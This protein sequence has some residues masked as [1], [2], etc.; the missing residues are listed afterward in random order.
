MFRLVLATLRVRK[1]SAIAGFLAL[2]CAALIVGACGVLLETGIRGAIPAERYSGTPVVVA[3]DQ[4]IRWTETKVKDKGDGEVKTKSKEKAK[5]LSERAWLPTSVGDKL[6]AVPGAQVIEDLIFPADVLADGG[7]LPGVDGNPTWG[8]GWSSAALT[9]YVLASGAEPRGDGDVVID[10]ELADRAGL[11]VGDETVVQSTSTPKTYRVTGIARPEATVD[12]QS[13]LFFTA[14]EARRLAGHDGTVSAYGVFGA[15]RDQVEA[16]VAGTEAVVSSGD[17]RGAVE[18]VDAAS[19][20]VKLTSMGGALA[21]TSLIV[22]ML[23]VVGTFALAVQ[24]RYREL[25]MLRAIGATPRQ[26]RKMISRE[27]L[28][29]GVLAAIPGALL[30]IPLASVIRAKFVSLGTI[31]DSLQLARSPFPIIAAMAATVGAAFIAARVTA[32]RTARIRP[33]E[34]LAEAAI[35]R[36][37]LGL[38]R[39]LAGLIFTVLAAC[40]T[41]LLTVLH[42]EPAAMPV[43][44]LSVLM[45]M[46]ALSLLGPYLTRG[47]I[48][49]LGVPL[50][51]FPVGGFLAALNSK[52]NSRRVASVIT[53]LALLIGMTSTILFVP[54]TLSDAAA[55]EMKAG[56]KADYVVASLG[57]G[58]PAPAAEALR[59]TPGVTSVTEVLNTTIWAGQDKRSAQG[60]SSAGVATVVDP[61]VTTGSLEK[62]A[63]GSIAMSDLAVQ[64]RKIGDTVPV[65]MGDGV[66]TKFQLVAVY[67]RALGFGDVLLAHE[68]VV[69]HVDAPLAR[70]VLIKGDVSPDQLRDRVKDFPG[71]MVTDRSGFQEAQ[72]ERQQTNAEVN[73]VFMGLIIAFT[74]IAV[75]NTLAMAIVDRIREFALMR[76]VGTTRRQVFDVLHWELGVIVLIAAALGTGAALLTLTGFSTGMV[77]SSTPSISLGT[78]A[79]VLL[80]ALG[81]GLVATILPARMVL[82]R[83]PAE[84]IN[85][86]Q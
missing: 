63:P 78:Y 36:R 65:T 13:A 60:L 85:G 1:G 69:G 52:A 41:L 18:F 81:L 30:G 9:P 12:Q 66:E 71:L 16:A 82:R 73:L 23:V 61:E 45:W 21:G 47:A 35:E 3:A 58:V 83:N 17:E 26:V 74:A 10:A 38:G 28:L 29:L 79:V 51:A 56:M 6:A 44:Y 37:T 50:R 14:G 19:A 39:V 31:P 55:D 53:P 70:T 32:R 33:A 11:E 43:T 86:R 27:A 4:Q 75:V 22:A 67:G 7:F 46:V 24:Q 42:T 84:D 20:R 2:F 8:H 72:A 62:L 40:I 77:G 25:A 54:V 68:D 5:A 76:L 59:G 80:G 64:G 15:G 49:L 57:S 48:G 34:A